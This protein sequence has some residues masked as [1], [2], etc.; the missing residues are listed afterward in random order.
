MQNVRR[1]LQQT[2]ELTTVIFLTGNVHE[3]VNDD[4]AIGLISSDAHDRQVLS[5]VFTDN[6]IA[7]HAFMTD[8]T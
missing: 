6:R 8:E 2:F 7:L 4:R 5:L 1:F 3:S